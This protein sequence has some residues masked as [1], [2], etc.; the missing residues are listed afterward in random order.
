MIRSEHRLGRDGDR[1][2][3]ATQELEHREQ[4]ANERQLNQ[5]LGREVLKTATIRDESFY[6]N[7]LGFWGD[8][9]NQTEA[10]FVKYVDDLISQNSVKVEHQ[11][12]YRETL[13]RYEDDQAYNWQ[14][15][16][17]N[18][19]QAQ[20]KSWF[21]NL[22]AQA[23][24]LRLGGV[25][26]TKTIEAATGIFYDD[27]MSQLTQRMAEV[28]ASDGARSQRRIE[29]ERERIGETWQK[30]LIY[31]DATKDYD[32]RNRDY[33][34]Y[35]RN[36]RAAHNNMIKQLNWLNDLAEKYQTQRFALRDFKTNDFTY[37]QKSDRGGHLN[38]WIEYDRETVLA[39]FKQA[40]GADFQ[41]AERK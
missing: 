1:S 35:Q 28:A 41:R 30:V 31:L 19:G 21:M 23:D 14:Q 26:P 16:Y 33:N 29:A 37:H 20:S 39:Y 25:E 2:N 12:D 7:E 3:E 40:F 38:H 10:Q 22:Y 36:R 13:S 11:K 34:Y 4:A 27:R 18:L 6:R 9:Y 5:Q 32:S 15:L 24:V 8:T 17:A